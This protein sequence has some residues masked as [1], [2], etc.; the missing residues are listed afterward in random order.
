MKP[1]LF[2]LYQSYHYDCTRPAVCIKLEA[3]YVYNPHW[4]E[5][6]Y[7]TYYKGKVVVTS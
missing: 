3:R 1:N 4:C 6:I 7:L 5:R 2:D